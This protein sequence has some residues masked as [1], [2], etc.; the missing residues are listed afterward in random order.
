MIHKIIILIV[1]ILFISSCKNQNVDKCESLYDNAL[2]CQFRSTQTV[3]TWYYTNQINILIVLKVFELK[4]AL[5]FAMRDYNA[6]KRYIESF[7]IS[8]FGIPYK[9]KMYLVSFQLQS[10]NRIHL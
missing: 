8:D 1:S 10:D 6:G 7:D 2:D 3:D 9:K 5:M 4:L